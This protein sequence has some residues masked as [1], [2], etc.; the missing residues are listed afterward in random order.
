MLT[1]IV[2]KHADMYPTLARIAKDVCAIPATSVPCERLFSGGG[3]IA[4]DQRSQLGVDKFEYLQVLK[5][6]WRSGISD[7]A[8]TNSSTVESIDID[9][10]HLEQFKE[11]L[12][13]DGKMEHKLKVSELVITN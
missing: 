6:A 8:T 11:L 12:V 5:H 10:V 13:Y 9:E 1:I 4:T 7:R 3:K 2:Q